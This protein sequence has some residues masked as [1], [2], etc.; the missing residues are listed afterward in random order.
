M[1]VARPPAGGGVAGAWRR[2]AVPSSAGLFDLGPEGKEGEEAR[3]WTGEP[4]RL[5][6]RAPERRRVEADMS[7]SR[8]ERGIVAL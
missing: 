2:A 3:F 8:T 4:M 6:S 5:S 7:A 1:P